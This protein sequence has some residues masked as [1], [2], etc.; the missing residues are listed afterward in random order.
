LIDPIRIVGLSGVGKTRLVQAF[1]DNRIATANL[2][3]DQ[4]NVLYTDLSDNPA[5]QP[6]A[7]LEA[8][9]QEVSESVVVV[10]NC[11]QDVHQKLTEIVKRVDSKVRLVTFEY[12]ISVYAS[13]YEQASRRNE[14]VVRCS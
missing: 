2:S 5:P 6:T 14:H 8:V 9:I 4:D 1:F 13:E 10:D 12:D 11:R 7:M 3:L